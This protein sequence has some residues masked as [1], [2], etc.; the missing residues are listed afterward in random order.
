MHFDQRT[1]EQEIDSGSDTNPSQG[2][3]QLT[4]ACN[5]NDCVPGVRGTISVT[6]GEA[7]NIIS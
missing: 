7:D 5:R 6:P 2:D 1:G 3:D 4:L